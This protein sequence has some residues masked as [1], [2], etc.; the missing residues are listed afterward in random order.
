M[1]KFFIVL[2][3][4]ILLSVDSPAN[5]FVNSQN[6]VSQSDKKVITLVVNGTG[7]SKE[8]AVRNALRSAIEQAFGTFVSANTEVL[9]D[10]MVK[11]E[12][13][14]VSSG[15]ILGYKEL[16]CNSNGN[17][18]TVSLLAT[19]SIGNLISYAQ[20]KGM[21]AELAGA[22]FAMNM[23]LRKLNKENEL[24]AMENLK[25]QL[26]LMAKSGLFDF[27]IEIGE[28]HV[29]ADYGHFGSDGKWA[30]DN[31][32][33]IAVD[34]TIKQIVNSKTIEFRETYLKVLY[35]LALSSQEKD[36]YRSA[37]LP[38]YGYYGHES[39]NGGHYSLRNKYDQFT[40]HE[41]LTFARYFFTIEDN[42]GHIINPYMRVYEGEF[43]KYEPGGNKGMRSTI[44]KVYSHTGEEKSIVK[45]TMP[46]TE[47][48]G[49]LYE[50]E[51]TLYMPDFRTA[52]KASNNNGM[53]I[54]IGSMSS[55]VFSRK[56][57]GS[58]G[59]DNFESWRDYSSFIKNGLSI[60]KKYSETRFKLYYSQTEI[61]KL[62]SIQVNPVLAN[63]NI[64]KFVQ[65][66]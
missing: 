43:Y 36:D 40:F 11:D 24:K 8:V 48:G 59:Y 10:D 51:N 30:K 39:P 54:E 44:S 38:F 55:M 27:Q 22:T 34:V 45:N 65:L 33:N 20:N 58:S 14:T 13:V 47:S 19:V 6:E 26:C 7:N 15:N 66:H 32:H 18:Y 46:S 2:I 29:S 63:I 64:E 31:S 3:A 21:E 12:I 52:H 23:K 37:G 4:G 42:L 25:K 16:Y 49:A 50:W 28:P 1:K 60:G 61:E 9:N 41:I 5:G 17:N 53:F 57:G 62:N 35:Y 56:I